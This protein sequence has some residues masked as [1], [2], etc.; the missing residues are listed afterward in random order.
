[1]GSGKTAIGRQL[2]RLLGLEFKDSDQ[3]VQERTGVDIPFI[4]EKEGEAGFRQREARIIDELTRGDNI[5]LAT[6]GGVILAAENRRVLAE[7]GTVI[8]LHASVVT[9]LARTR[10]GRHRPLLDETDP[11][12]K[13]QSL[14]S[15][16]DP[17]YRAIAHHIVPTDN[18]RVPAVARKIQSLLELAP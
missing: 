5:V 4:F 13:L 12:T 18:H 10:R 17:L 2:A 9:Q 11:A 6:G 3:V 14:F 15:I 1:M 16:R 8:Y 7:R